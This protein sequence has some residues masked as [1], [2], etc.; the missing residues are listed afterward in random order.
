MTRTMH[1]NWTSARFAAIRA[2]L[3]G[4]VCVAFSVVVLGLPA[5]AAQPNMNAPVN[6]LELP[7]G[8][9]GCPNPP[10]QPGGL[11]H[12]LCYQVAT[13]Q[14]S[15][16]L[17][18]LQDQFGSYQGVQPLPATAGATNDNQL[19]NPVTKTLSDATGGLVGPQYPVSNPQAHLYCFSDNTGTTPTVQVSVQNQFGTGT[20]SVGKSTRLCLPSWKYDPNQDPTSG[21]ASGSVAPTAW[22][23]PANLNL[24]HFQCYQVVPPNAVGGGFSNKPASVQLQDQFGVYQTVTI[25]APKELCAP[26]IKQV[27]SASGAPVGGP[28]AIN[29]D[30]LQG[31]HLLCFAVDVGG[32]HNVSVGNQFSATAASPVPN[33]VQVG[34][35][36]ADQLCLPSFKTV[37]PPP[38]TPEV[39]TVVLLPLAG[40]LLGGTWFVV[41]RRRRSQVA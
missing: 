26:V 23:D 6:C 37:I 34:V 39:A 33:P 13:D 4:I 12:F 19:C 27:V 38:Q 25:G 11:D 29:A 32:P 21:L 5:S 31:A 20:L 28:S 1:L 16:P 35:T 2:G 36:F 40:A 41:H 18:N 9:G 17:V 8:G 7:A 22:T 24:N 14:F 15:P 3:A 30:G 10:T